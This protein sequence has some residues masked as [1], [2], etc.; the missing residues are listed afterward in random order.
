MYLRSLEMHGFK[1][2]PD[3]TELKF[4]K[5]IT[6]VVGPNGSGKSNIADAMRWVM[7]EQSSKALRGEKMAGVIFHGCNTRKESPFS[8][9]T[10]TIDNED[11][12][13]D[14]ESDVVAVSRKLYRN[15]DSEYM[16]NGKAARLKE[17]NELFMDTGLGKDGYSIIGQGKIADIVNGKSNERREIFEEA[18]G[19]AKFR[20]KKQEAEKKLAAA[21]ENVSRLNDILAELEN[22]IGPLQKQCEKAKRFRVLDD[23]KRK[24]E[25]SVWVYRLEEYKT[26]L[27]EFEERIALLDSQHSQLAEELSGAEK[28]IDRN[29]EMSAK[30]A[31]DVENYRQQM[32]MKELEKQNSMSEAAVCENDISHMKENIQQLKDRIEQSRADRYFY[33]TE[34]EKRRAGLE[35]LMEQ[36][37]EAARLISEKENEFTE[38]ATKAE[39]SDKSVSDVNSAISAAYLKKSKL[40]FQIESVKNTIAETQDSISAAE[41]TRKQLENDS[42]FAQSELK[43]LDAERKKANEDKLENQNRLEGLEKLF[44]VRKQKLSQVSKEFSDTEISAQ[45]ISGKLQMLRDLE[46]SMEGFGYSVKHIMKAVKQGRI[47]G[48]CGSVAQ[49]ITVKSEYSVAVE[50]A[51][52]GALQNIVVENE[53]CAKRGIRLLKENKAG[54]ATFLPITTVKGTRLDSRNIEHENGYVAMGSDLVQCDSRYSGIISYLLGRICIAEDI[55]S[56][57]NIARKN[58]FKFRIVTLDGQVINSGGS[59]TGGSVSKNTGILT[60]KNEIEESEKKLSVLNAKKEELSAKRERLVQEVDK[61]SADIE[62]AKENLNILG[63]TCI[64]LEMEIKRVRE[65]TERFEGS[66]RENDSLAE[67]LG[68]KLKEANEELENAAQEAAAEDRNILEMEAELEKTQSAQ[69]DLRQ[70]RE[71]IS[72]ELSELRIKAAEI[73]KDIQSA[74]DSVS[75]LSASIE[76][77]ENGSGKTE[78]EIAQ[79]ENAIEEKKKHIKEITSGLSGFDDETEKLAELI[80]QARQQHIEY[81]AAANKLRAAQKNKLEEKSTLAQQL[82]RAEERKNTVTADFDKLAAQLWDE[83]ELTRSTAAEQAEKIEDM[84]AANKRLTELKNQIRGLG[85]VNLEAID[86]YAEVS[87][88]YEMMTW[89]LNDVNVSKAELCEMIDSLTEK[90]K[91]VFMQNFDIINGNFK[92]IFSELFGGGK[93]ELTLTDPENVL[94]CG[95]EINVQPPGKVITSLMS[96][97]GGEQ[98]LV[99]IA[100]YFAILKNS[101]SPFCL[102]DEIEAALDDV[103]VSRY[104]QYLHRLTDKTQFITITH[105]RGTMEEADVLYGVTMQEKG[106]SKL[107]RMSV[108]E[109]RQM[110]FEE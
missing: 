53:D 60:R 91:S 84:P 76:T 9:V 43:K 6:A 107:L 104:A 65:I 103:N 81:D 62:S 92:K 5:G 61:F 110:K 101:P 37:S 24:L 27:D 88:R 74:K 55:D 10:I 79:I 70:Q 82:T 22:R 47:S 69:S 51:L 12:A 21:E 52:G 64:K 41:E 67:Q 30:C 78:L 106:I 59:F 40:S 68:K 15:G 46:N 89:Q 72:R 34:L 45:Q 11:R 83:Y 99:A 3:K 8:Q 86:E 7:G 1:S 32:H 26:K 16:I 33:E 42:R 63:N 19:I 73:N 28:E 100:I 38:L 58:G 96:L 109:T 44:D 29:F 18:A 75:Q 4:N 80:E 48:V 14:I 98:A 35:E 102:L 39:E 31:A 108:E 87:E 50:T 105:R 36:Q 25:V 94:E 97:S 95:I 54:R 77:N 57:T 90:M 20:Y 23:E 49:L 71:D 2:F 13:L 66:V 85:S 56:A 93:A 17:V